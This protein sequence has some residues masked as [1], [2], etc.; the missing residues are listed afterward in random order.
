MT[1]AC[2]IC[3]AG[4]YDGCGHRCVAEYGNGRG[5]RRTCGHIGPGQ[6]VYPMV[7]PLCASHYAT[8][9]RRELEDA[10]RWLTE[11]GDT[12]E[13]ADLPSDADYLRAIGPG[14]ARLR[15]AVTLLA[16][17]PTAPESDVISRSVGVA[18]PAGDVPVA[19]AGRPVALVNRSCLLSLPPSAMG[20]CVE[21]TVRLVTDERKEPA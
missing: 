6:R 10:A 20:R 2:G 5:K 19:L 14:L 17:P 1:P 18:R 4:R 7:G 11:L 16:G 9:G 3:G 21:V 15:A 12:A 8:V 13:R